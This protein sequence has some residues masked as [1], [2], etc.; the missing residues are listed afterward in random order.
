MVRTLSLRQGR[1]LNGTLFCYMQFDLK[2]K[3]IHAIKW[4]FLDSVGT[5]GV[6][7]VSGIVLAR[8]L[9]PEQF[10]LIGMLTIFIAVAQ[11][12][13]DSGFGSALIQ[14]RDATQKD[15]CSIFYFNIAVGLIASGVLCVFA[16]GISAFYNQPI[17]TPLLRVLSISLVINSFGLVQSTMLTK[18]VNFKTLAKVNLIATILAAVIGISMAV[19]GF[20]VWSLV[21][22]QISI[23]FLGTAFLWLS[24]IWKPAL[25]FSM[26]SLREMFGFGS[27]VLASG[28]LNTFFDNIYLLV[29]GRLFS[30]TQLGFF[31]R[32]KTLAELPSNQLTWTIGRVM[33]PV[34][35]A[36]QDDS[37]RLKRGLKKTLSTLAMVNF[38]LMIGILVIARPL[39]LVLLTEKWASCIP[40]LQ[41]LCINCILFPLNWININVLYA[42]GRSDLCLRLEIIKKG[43]IVINII[44]TCWWGIRAMIC[45]QIAVSIFAYY[46][47]CYYNGILIGYSIKEQ[48]LD[49]LSYLFVSILMGLIVYTLSYLLLSNSW[50]V[51]L[52]EILIGSIVYMGLCWLFKLSVFLEMW[53]MGWKK[54]SL[55]KTN[56]AC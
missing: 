32:A 53:N 48:L 51:L 21:V 9:L 28:L 26:K 20:G 50:F 10:G 24:N 23:A 2:N 33:F 49:I 30:A 14:K 15:I 19:N 46:L 29:I 12:F 6:Q 35:S 1:S 25:I 47:N 3:T 38:P 40:Y 52:F 16:P 7:F 34:F 44:V 36:V 43:L 4:S 56:A 37:V 13:L 41:L 31:S 39:V 42:I 45:G 54:I 18:Q 27:R 17:L 8:L 11:S 55:L 22:Q 5:R